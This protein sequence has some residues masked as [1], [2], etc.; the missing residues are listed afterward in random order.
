MSVNFFFPLNTLLF[1]VVHAHMLLSQMSTFLSHLNTFYSTQ[2]SMNFSSHMKVKFILIVKYTFLVTSACIFLMLKPLM[3]L[4]CTVLD[5]S[6]SRVKIY[7]YR[8][9]HFVVTKF[10]TCFSNEHTFSLFLHFTLA[11]I[12]M[13]LLLLTAEYIHCYLYSL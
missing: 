9:M 4:Y 2:L 13:C 11:Y 5:F 12:Y 8:I 10:N 6:H 1:T 7:P 3:S